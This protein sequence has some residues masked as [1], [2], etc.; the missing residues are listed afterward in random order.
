MRSRS[1]QARRAPRARRALALTLLLLGAGCGGAAPT[2]ATLV[3]AHGASGARDQ[4]RLRLASRPSDATSRRALI[5]LELELG[6]PGA[7]LAHLEVL[8]AAGAP[9]G[10]GLQATDRRRLGTLLL[11]RSTIRTARLAAARST[12]STG[13]AASAS[14]PAPSCGAARSWRG[15]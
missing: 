2:P 14:S 6:H 8:A 7:A 5:A 12:T 9:L 1:I 13:P 15:R 10:D 3:R 11:A 4:L